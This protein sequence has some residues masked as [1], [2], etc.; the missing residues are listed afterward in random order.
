MCWCKLGGILGLL[1]QDPEGLLPAAPIRVEHEITPEEI[2]G[3]IADRNAARRDKEF[4]EADRIRDL[5]K[6][7]GIILDDARDGTTWRRA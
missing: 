2:E 6:E 4:A 7:R 5:L 1:Q 3:L